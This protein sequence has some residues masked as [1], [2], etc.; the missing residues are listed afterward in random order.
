MRSACVSNDGNAPGDAALLSPSSPPLFPLPFP[1]FDPP[2]PVLVVMD[3]GDVGS[4]GSGVPV[5]VERE[6]ERGVHI[7]MMY[8]L[9]YTHKGMGP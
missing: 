3:G 4:A 2:P 1:L 5:L 8:T 6:R 7:M 9:L